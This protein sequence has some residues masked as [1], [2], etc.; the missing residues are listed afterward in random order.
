M[1]KM[2]LGILLV[3]AV[4]TL[5]SVASAA[6]P[7][8]VTAVIGHPGPQSYWDVDV[9]NGGNVDLPTMNDYVGWC[10]DSKTGL[11]PGT[12]SFKVYS[13]LSPGSLPSGFP[14]VQW[15]KV[16]YVIN[17]KGSADKFTVQAVIWH[18]DG[19][20]HN[21]GPLNQ[22]QMESSADYL[23]LVA[24][25]DANPTYVPVAGENYAVILWSRTNAQP[26]FIEVPVP[27]PSIPEFPTLALPVAMLIGVVGA[28][29]LFK[30]RKE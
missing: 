18:Y 19:G 20:Y 17:H 25:A 1:R 21:W 23:A 24:A 28:V 29:Q 3:V 6:L 26:V 16:N 9:T 27:P 13:S 10:A 8:S 12:F 30:T 11:G 22:V 15:N 5:V 7:A 2:Q 14:T 4:I